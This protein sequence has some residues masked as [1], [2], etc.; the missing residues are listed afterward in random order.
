MSPSLADFQLI[1][2]MQQPGC[3]ICRIRNL[4]EKRYLDNLLL[5]RVNDGET[6]DHLIASFG[7]C[8]KHTWQMGFL[9]LTTYQEPVKNS[10]LYEY[11]VNYTLRQ[12]RQYRKKELSREKGVRGWLHRLFHKKSPFPFEQDPFAPLIMKGC[13]VCEI[14]AQEETYFLHALLIGLGEERDEIRTI[15][16]SSEGLCLYHFRK[17][18]A[19]REESLSKPLDFL[20]QTT[21]QKMDDLGNDLTHFIDKH[22]LGHSQEP[23]T[24]GER[25]SWVRALR[26]IGMHEDDTIPGYSDAKNQDANRLEEQLDLHLRPAGRLKEAVEEKRNR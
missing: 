17:S 23:L 14:G 22:S 1:P 24:M 25:T 20:V 18:F 26:L 8:P 16:Q 3:P 15:Y 6:R 9:D 7:F 13:Y 2:A 5:E 21:I 10:M 12:L 4:H 11:L 19:Y